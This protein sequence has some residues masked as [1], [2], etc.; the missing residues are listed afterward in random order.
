MDKKDWIYI[1]ALLIYTFWYKFSKK[2]DAQSDIRKKFVTKKL[3]QWNHS[4]LKHAL[5]TFKFHF[6]IIRAHNL[7]NQYP[8]F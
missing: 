6:H 1:D 2:F 8:H 4:Y 7:L 3:V 5:K